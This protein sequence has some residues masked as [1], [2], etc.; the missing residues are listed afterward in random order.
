MQG[1][2]TL[3]A[4]K[5]R[6]VEGSATTKDLDVTIWRV[7]KPSDFPHATPKLIAEGPRLKDGT[8]L[9]PVARFPYYQTKP[10]KR[11]RYVTLNCFRWRL[12]WID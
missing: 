8:A 3:Y 11:N 12:E 5:E 1:L 9:F 10:D 4:R 2:L 6:S 7:M